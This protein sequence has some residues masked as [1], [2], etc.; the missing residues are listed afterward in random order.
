MS[1][2]DRD[3]AFD[4]LL[5]LDGQI[6]YIGDRGHRVQFEVT[7]SVAMAERPHGLRYSLTVHGPRGERIAGFDN[8]HAVPATKGPGGRRATYDHRHRFKTVR[9]YDYTDAAALLE[10]FWTLAEAVLKEEGVKI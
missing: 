5:N 8:A 4:V 1:A 6:F 9:P 10:D 2:T 7:E 3:P